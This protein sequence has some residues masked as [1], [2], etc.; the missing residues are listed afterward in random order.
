MEEQGPSFYRALDNR[1]EKQHKEFPEYTNEKTEV[2]RPGPT[3]KR[4]HPLKKLR[5]RLEEYLKELPVLGFNSG[6]YD[7]NA[8]KEF[9]FLVLVKNEEV[10]FTI[11][12]NNN[13]MCLKSA[14]LCFLDVTNFL[15]PGFSYDKFLKAYECPQTK[16]FFPYS[17]AKT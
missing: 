9:L 3:R 4:E 6:K 16:G 14:H 10:L 11:K 12:C 2:N 13:I 17:L 15:A 7:L 1:R 8:V 5:N